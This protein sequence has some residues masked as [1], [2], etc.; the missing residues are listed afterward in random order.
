[1]LVNGGPAIARSVTIDPSSAIEGKQLP[2]ISGL[3]RL[4]V[5]LQ[6]GQTMVFDITVAMDDAGLIKAVVRWV[7]DA[8]SQEAPYTL[9]TR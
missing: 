3:D 7:D 6:P 4:P 2:F 9:E 8:G 5:D 1:M